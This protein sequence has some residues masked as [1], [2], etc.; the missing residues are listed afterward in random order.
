[1]FSL[2]N[3]F[4]HIFLKRNA[5]GSITV[6][7]MPMDELVMNMFAHEILAFEMQSNQN[8]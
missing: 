7:I 5:K 1:M 4:V 6:I 8:F 3:N 2:R